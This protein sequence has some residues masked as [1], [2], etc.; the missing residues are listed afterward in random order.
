MGRRDLRRRIW[1]YA[2]CP[3]PI[4]RTLGLYGL[5]LRFSRLSVYCTR[6]AGWL[7]LSYSALFCCILNGKRISTLFYVIYTYIIKIKLGSFKSSEHTKE[8]G[9]GPYRGFGYLSLFSDTIYLA[10]WSQRELL[11][12]CVFQQGSRCQGVG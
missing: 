11:L 10:T 9:D 6:L 4:K 2:G 8:K 1:G 7:L 5:M 12:F 3:C